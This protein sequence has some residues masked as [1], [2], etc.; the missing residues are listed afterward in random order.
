MTELSDNL[1]ASYSEDPS[2]DN[3]DA[4]ILNYMNLVKY[5]AS[6][7]SQGLPNTVEQADLISY[8]TFGLI[9]AIG[10]FEPERGFK[11]ETFA[12][13]RIRGAMLDEIR[14]IDWVPRST[15]AKAKDIDRA[16][17]ELEGELRRH[18]S[19]SE[20]AQALDMTDRQY[21][22][23]VGQVSMVKMVSIDSPVMIQAT[24]DLGS[25]AETL[26]QPSSS[27]D[28]FWE[29]QDR[30]AES[31]EE[32][33]LREK[34][35]IALYYYEGLTLAEIGTV[36]GVTESRVCQIHTKAIEALQEQLRALAP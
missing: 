21:A 33:S 14:S 34:S 20:M 1:W 13:S 22:E 29:I 17:Q 25:V 35:V 31:I 15:R 32:M 26:A 10:R 11:F 4:L 28:I 27:T 16:G 12:M 36:L 18:A 9:D 23:A 3:R 7:V 6:K 24:G 2:R 8:G 30:L 5:V 19:P